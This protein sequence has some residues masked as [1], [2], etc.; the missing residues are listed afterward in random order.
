MSGYLDSEPVSLLGIAE[1]YF[2]SGNSLAIRPSIFN[3][4]TP[5]LGARGADQGQV[6]RQGADRQVR[7][8][9]VVLQPVP[10]R[11]RQGAQDVDLPGT[12]C[13]KIGLPGKSILGDYFQENRTSRRPFPLLRIIFPGRPTFIQFMPGTTICS[14][15]TETKCRRGI[16]PRPPTV[17]PPRPPSS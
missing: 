10:R 11:V 8:G 9:H 4:L 13:I 6:H 14:V 3:F 1:E 5:L 2:M 7:G 12:N 16:P 17:W 15:G